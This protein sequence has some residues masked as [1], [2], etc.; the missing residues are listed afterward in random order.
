MVE[1]LASVVAAHDTT[2]RPSF[3]SVF[4]YG[5]ALCCCPCGS[6]LRFAAFEPEFEE[7]A[8]KPRIVRV[9]LGLELLEISAFSEFYLL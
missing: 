9:P 2:G 7:A 5:V 6:S 3:H 4:A 8:L 1:N